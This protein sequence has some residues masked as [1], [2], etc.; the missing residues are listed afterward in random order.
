MSPTSLGKAASLT[1]ESLLVHLGCTSLT[2]A[3]CYLPVRIRLAA[4]QASEAR[5]N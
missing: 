1:R 2:Q 5:L 3:I 4:M